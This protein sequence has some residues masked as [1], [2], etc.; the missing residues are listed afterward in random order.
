[1][2]LTE[3]FHFKDLITNSPS[4]LSYNSYDVSLENLV[5][6]QLTIPQLKF[7]LNLINFLLEIVLILYGE[8]LLVIH[9]SLIVN[10]LKQAS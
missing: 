3:P 2:Y 5:L 6:D 1:M 8:I 7:F 4:C 9:G 10:Q